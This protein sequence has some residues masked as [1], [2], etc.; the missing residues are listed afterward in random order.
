MR[1]KLTLKVNKEKFGDILPLSYQYELSAAVY[2]I[3]SSADSEYATWL[4]DNGF[5]LDFKKRFKF[6][7]FSRLR[8]PDSRLLAHEGK[9]KIYSD[10]IDW[11]IT[12][13]PER[14]TKTFIEGLFMNQTFEVGSDRRTTVQ[15]TIVS[16][17]AMPEP[18]YSE[19]MEFD[20]ISPMCIKLKDEDNRALYLSPSDVRAPYL[21]FNGLI[22]RYKTFY[23]EQPPFSASDCTLEV[24]RE[25]K[26]ALI[27]VKA[28]TPNQT[29]VRGYMCSF[30]VKAPVEIMKLIYASGIGSMNAIGFGCVEIKP[31]ANR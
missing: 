1:F 28:G 20:T 19:D 10:I 6:F 18:E 31:P 22:D 16:V 29:R 9:L 12:F 24:T 27:T 2:R 14:S 8:I 17:E 11:Q 30:K 15:F 13:L 5:E 21:I 7:T 25:P 26:S 3:L 23:H 4:H